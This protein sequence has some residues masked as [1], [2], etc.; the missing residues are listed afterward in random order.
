MLGQVPY[1]NDF[2][3]DNYP[4]VYDESEEQLKYVKLGNKTNIDTGG[5]L[6]LSATVTLTDAQIK[7]LPT[8]GIQL[9]A[10]PGANKINMVVS[11]NWVLDLTSSYTGVDDASP[12]LVYDAG[13]YIS[14]AFNASVPLGESAGQ[15]FGQFQ[16][17]FIAD[18]AGNFAGWPVTTYVG[19]TSGITNKAIRLFDDFNS[20]SNYTGGNA[21][22]TLKIT[23][24]YITVDL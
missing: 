21:A 2:Q 5:G 15:Y 12:Q 10:A 14:G 8:T 16:I 18:G 19:V 24:Y 13:F 1:Q 17:P 3:E 7:A 9:V 22:N 23:V 6:L 4:V 20:P 11:A